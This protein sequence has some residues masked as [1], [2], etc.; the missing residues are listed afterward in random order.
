MIKKISK[1]FFAVLIL[2]LV[3]LPYVAKKSTS[4]ST[5]SAEEKASTESSQ[6]EEKVKDIRDTLKEQVREKVQEKLEEVK[7]QNKV[8][9]FFGELKEIAEKVLTI[10]AL[11]GER[12]A[13]ITDDTEIVLFEKD[14]KQTIKFNDLALGDFTIVMGYAT[15][16]GT[17]EA[18]RI[19][20]TKKAPETIKRDALLGEIQSFDNSSI[21]LKSRLED[22]TYQVKTDKKTKIERRIKNELKRIKITSLAEGDIILAVGKPSKEDEKIL[23]ASQIRVI[24]SKTPDEE[25]KIE[26]ETPKKSTPSS[27]TSE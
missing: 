11:S 4:Q 10:E 21:L 14:K 9:G 26:E 23:E 17:V 6:E 13:K 15:Q 12:L 18:K 25:I 1:Y 22:K 2:F 8:K 5:P 19:V 7:T 16:N 27:E 24:S 3:G 20:V